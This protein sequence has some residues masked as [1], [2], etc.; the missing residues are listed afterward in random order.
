MVAAFASGKAAAA[1]KIHREYY[2]RFKDLV[3]ETNPVPVKAALAMMGQIEEE[4]RLPLVPMSAKN[5]EVLRAT[6]KAVGVLR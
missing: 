2:P 4:Y 6:M 5:R 3:I 1:L